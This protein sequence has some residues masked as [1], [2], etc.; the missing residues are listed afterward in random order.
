MTSGTA[1]PIITAQT[2]K[3]TAAS[4]PVRDNRADCISPGLSCN[5]AKVAGATLLSG[6]DNKLEGQPAMLNAMT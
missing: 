5:L 1:H 2:G 6:G 3:R 4:A